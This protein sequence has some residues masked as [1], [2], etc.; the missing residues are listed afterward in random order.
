MWTTNGRWQARRPLLDTKALLSRIP[1]RL[2][3]ARIGASDRPLDPLQSLLFV[4]LVFFYALLWCRDVVVLSVL[5]TALA[6]RP[7]G[8][9]WRLLTGGRGL[10][11]TRCTQPSARWR[12]PMPTPGRLD[13]TYQRAALIVKSSYWKRTGRN[14]DAEIRSPSQRPRL[15]FGQGETSR[16]RSFLSLAEGRM[17]P[18][19]CQQSSQ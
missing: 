10:P 19:C 13:N 1:R 16:A 2:V 17:A 18:L 5:S 8:P 12:R 7:A 14:R 3:L 15:N 9:G 6:R 4:F 11:G